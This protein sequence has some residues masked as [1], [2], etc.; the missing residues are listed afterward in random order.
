MGA[1]L[2]ERVV[3]CP[4]MAP[5]DPLPKNLGRPDAPIRLA[6]AAEEE[7]VAAIDESY[8]D[9]KLGTLTPAWEH[10]GRPRPSSKPKP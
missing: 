3:R 1:R 8:E 5:H 7:L 9:Q 6:S 4:L 2:G 10:L